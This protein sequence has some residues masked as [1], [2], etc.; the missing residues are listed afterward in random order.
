MNVTRKNH[1]SPCNC[2][3]TTVQLQQTKR[4]LLQRV[5]EFEFDIMKGAKKMHG[6][7][8]GDK[9]IPKADV[10]LPEATEK[11]NGMLKKKSKELDKPTV[12][13]FLPLLKSTSM[14]SAASSISTHSG[15]TLSLIRTLCIIE[16]LPESMFIL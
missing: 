14:P 2:N 6:I 4:R 7:N 9:K 16:T 12:D 3:V 15:A 11:L 8:G 5:N 10:K 1:S 13:D